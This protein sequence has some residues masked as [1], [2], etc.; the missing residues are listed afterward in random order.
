GIGIADQLTEAIVL[1]GLSVDQAASRFFC[2]D[3]HGLLTDDMEDLRDFQRPYARAAATV[4]TWARDDELGGIG[5]AEVVRRVEPTIL[6]GT[7]G[8]PGA[9]TE[10]IVR[11]MACNVEH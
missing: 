11:E 7:S 3:K 10:A 8:R 4:A 9:F 6:I 2:V 5:L 1:S